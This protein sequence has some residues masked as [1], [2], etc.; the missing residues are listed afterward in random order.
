MPPSV[1]SQW[2]VKDPPP[3]QLTTVITVLIPLTP[4]SDWD[5]YPS[6]PVVAIRLLNVIFAVLSCF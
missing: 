6:A 1:N 2:T 5:N 3:P 4:P